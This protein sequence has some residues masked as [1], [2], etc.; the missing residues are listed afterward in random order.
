MPK[1]ALC[2][3]GYVGSF[4]VPIWQ[5][6]K[7]DERVLNIGYEHFQKHLFDKNNVDVFIHSW[8]VGFEDKID[9]L[10]KP[11]SAIYQEQ[12]KFKI[13]KHLQRSVRVNDFYSRWYTQKK[14]V[15]LKT[16]Y[17]NEH[18]FKYDWC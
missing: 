3:S 9:K 14:S 1:V 18:N 12:I 11:K 4:S 10:Y 17:E 13:P 16:Q 8:D 5:E 2:L 7:S 6:Y 15:E